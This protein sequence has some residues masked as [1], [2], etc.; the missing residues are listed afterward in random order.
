MSFLLSSGGADQVKEW[1][2]LTAAQRNTIKS[3]YNAAGIALV[4]SAFG[5]TEQRMLSALEHTLPLRLTLTL[6]FSSNYFR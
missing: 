4:A 6:A 2:L 3:Q 1:E 5:S